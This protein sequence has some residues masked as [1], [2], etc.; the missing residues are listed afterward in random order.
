MPT[1]YINRAIVEGH[2]PY[3]QR[4]VSAIMLLMAGLTGLFEGGQTSS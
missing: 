2:A 1:Q 4:Q 3:A